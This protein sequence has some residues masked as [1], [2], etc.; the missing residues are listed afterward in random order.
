MI[1]AIFSLTGIFVGRTGAFYCAIILNGALS[2]LLITS[3]VEERAKKFRPTFR[4]M[5]NTI[6]LI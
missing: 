6:Y 1:P 5:G 2:R 3:Q 4:L